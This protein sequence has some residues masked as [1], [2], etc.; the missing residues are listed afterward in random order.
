MDAGD[1]HALAI[2]FVARVAI[3]RVRVARP[4]RPRVVAVVCPLPQTVSPSCASTVRQPCGSSPGG[5]E[6]VAAGLGFQRLSGHPHV[7]AESRVLQQITVAFLPDHRRVMADLP[8]HDG[9]HDERRALLTEGH[10]EVEAKLLR[11]LRDL[12]QRETLLRG[13]GS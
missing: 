11:Q 8:M 9:R 5:N 12:R 10:L 13:S 6:E 3:R 4:V 1:G 2:V 7:I